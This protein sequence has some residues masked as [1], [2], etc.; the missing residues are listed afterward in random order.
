VQKSYRQT[1]DRQR[2][3][4]D[5]TCSERS[6]KIILVYGE[7]TFIRIFAGDHPSEGVKVKHT[8]S[9]AIIGPI[10]GHNLETVYRR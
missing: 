1:D 2:I 8:L 10:I 3:Y 5:T 9:L 7:I 4:D 6:L